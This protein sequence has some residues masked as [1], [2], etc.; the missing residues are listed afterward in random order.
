MLWI[1][2]IA[3]GEVAFTNL[4]QLIQ[5]MFWSFVIMEL[6]EPKLLQQ[7]EDHTIKTRDVKCIS[8]LQSDIGCGML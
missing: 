6:E 1:F 7:V 2:H 5:N 3:Y 8:F 4:S